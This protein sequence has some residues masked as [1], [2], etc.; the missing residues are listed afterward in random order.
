MSCV[1]LKTPDSATKEVAFVPAEIVSEDGEFVEIKILQS[2]EGLKKDEVRR[3]PKSETRPRFNRGDGATAADNTA[4]VHLNDA[5]ILDNL[6]ARH[7]KDDI[8]TYTASV[9]L[10]VNPYK[11]IPSLYGDTQCQKYKG[12][13]I[14]SLPPHPYAIA[15]NAYRTLNRESV[16]QALLISGESGA[17]KT[18]TAKIVMQYL[19]FASGTTSDLASKIQARVLQAQPILESFGNAVTLRNSNSSRFGKYNRVYFDGDGVLVDAGIQ[20]YLLE[21]SRVVVHGER[22]RTYHVFYEMLQGLDESQLQAFHLDKS[23]QYRLLHNNG[24]SAGG[25]ED[26]DKS[27]FARFSAALETL[28]WDKESVKANC[29]VLAG[30]VH[31]G[32]I[33]K[34]DA[35]VE[36]AARAAQEDD[37]TSDTRT[38]EVNEDSVKFAAELL[39]M[40]ADELC[41]VLKRRKIKIPGRDSM[42]EV[43]RTPMQFRQALH[44][45][46]KAIYKR[47]F[48]QTVRRINDSFLEL[49]PEQADDSTWK[50]I[51]IL[52]IYG[53]ERLQR[54]SFEQ[55][56]INLAN[57]R[58]QQY[59]VENVLHAEQALYGREGLTWTGL[60]LPDSGPVVNTI[61]AVF[62]TL[63]DF[64]GRLAKGFGEGQQVSDDRFCEKVLK[65]SSQDA[66][67][68]EVLKAP[69]I[70]A[71][72]ARSGTGARQNEG[73]VITHYAGTVDYN[74][75]GWLDKNNDRLLLE[76]EE[77]VSESTMPLVKSL[78]EEDNKQTFRSIS[79][80]Y[81]RDLEALLTTLSEANLHYIRCFKPNAL[82]KEMSSTASLF[83]TRLCSVEPSSS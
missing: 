58:L 28:G 51:G 56:C 15:D 25:F 53:F 59:F 38:V 71:K 63:D 73:F 10:A 45:T 12:K 11:N 74:T 75:K 9:L 72:E 78:G 61:A 44:S 21:S 33:P 16:N 43:P 36:M 8:Y 30:L 4:L 22:E 29:Q 60:K 35:E 39:G 32:D 7:T 65:E 5:S 17:G 14:G 24:A 64:S 3:M 68:K 23:K 54:N 50:N 77:L 81:S 47:L 48:E 2:A 46:I 82:Q 52:D 66:E 19:A 31:L 20:T 67:R 62:K 1:W 13:H 79:A 37:E 80:K 76:C 83:L 18:E 40:D 70:S 42:H 34:E 55:L 57:E 6:A 27:N 26:R 69:K 41:G 49:R